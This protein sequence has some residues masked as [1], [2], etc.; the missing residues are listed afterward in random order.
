MLITCGIEQTLFLRKTSNLGPCSGE[1]A[2]VDFANRVVVVVVVGAGVKSALERIRH[3]V[4][5]SAR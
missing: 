2:G 4:D 3:E 5:T 1:R